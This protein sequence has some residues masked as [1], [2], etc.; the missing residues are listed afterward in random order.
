MTKVHPGK[1][2]PPQASFR[3][4][5]FPGDLILQIYCT[6]TRGR[7]SGCSAGSCQCCPRSRT[8]IRRY[9]TVQSFT[10]CSAAGAG[11]DCTGPDGEK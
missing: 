7:A 4:C 1:T 3:K 2:E 8:A 11:W 9:L 10:A 5:P 6:V